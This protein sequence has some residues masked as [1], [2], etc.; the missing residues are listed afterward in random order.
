MNKK[1]IILASVMLSYGCRDKG[2]DFVRKIPEHTTKP[3]VV[4]GMDTVKLKTQT[5]TYH[6][7]EGKL[8]G[9]PV[10][11]F[12]GPGGAKEMVCHGLDDLAKHT[13]WVKRVLPITLGEVLSVHGVPDEQR[14]EVLSVV[15]RIIDRYLTVDIRVDDPSAGYME[16]PSW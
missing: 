4:Y 5:Y 3:V 6:W 7:H 16:D 15:E 13:A 12:T 9:D 10:E 11:G 14:A 1:L 2:A 8:E